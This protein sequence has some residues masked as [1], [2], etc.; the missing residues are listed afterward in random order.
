MARVVI[1]L[2]HCYR[3]SGSTGTNGEQEFNSKAGGH[4]AGRLRWYGHEPIVMLA[5]DKPL[6][7]AHA[8]VAIHAD[9]STSPSAHGASVG[10]RDAKGQEFG[11]IWKKRYQALGWDGGF[12]GDNYTS[13]LRYYYGTGWAANA[14]ITH[15]IICEGGFLT[16]PRERGILLSE[17]GQVRFAQAVI[18]AVGHIFGHPKTPGPAPQPGEQ[19]DTVA[20]R[21]V[22]AAG[23]DVGTAIGAF[24]GYRPGGVVFVTNVDTARQY[25]NEGKADVV[26][27]GGPAARELFP[28]VAKKGTGVQRDGKRITVYGGSG[29]E[30][31]DL[32]PEAIGAA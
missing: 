32:G 10:Y 14:G 25:V 1:Q 11:A 31:Y 23:R 28:D 5:D 20:D 24:A 8:F 15:A 17:K 13:A 12:R 30:T 16:N 7:K 22:Y 19:G 6:P 27:F 9:G 26:A 29:G 21:V 4:L 18:D 3:K 2:G